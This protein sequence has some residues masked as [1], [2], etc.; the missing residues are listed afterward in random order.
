MAVNPSFITMLLAGVVALIL[1]LVGI[2]MVLLAGGIVIQFIIN[3][4]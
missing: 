2:F 4:I 3:T 1:L